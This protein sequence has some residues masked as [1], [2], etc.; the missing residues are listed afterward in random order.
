MGDSSGAAGLAVGLPQVGPVGQPAR[1][2]P[3][4]VRWLEALGVVLSPAAAALVLRLRLMAPSILPDPALHTSYI[5]EA[6][7]V[8]MRYAWLA[9]VGR[10][11]EG[12]RVG[13]LVPARLDYLAFGAVPG[14]FVTRYV[15]ALIAVGPVY[16]LLRR[17]YGPAAGVAGIVVVLSSP[18]I[19]TAWGTDY[20]DGAVVSYALGAMACLVMPGAPRWRRAWLAAAGVLMTLA[21]W[22]HLVG[23]P[24][25][26]ATLAAWLAVRL[27]RERAGLPGDLA[28]LAGVAAAVT[29]LLVLASAVLFGHANFFA[30]TWEGYRFLSQPSQTAIWHSASWR[31]APYVAYL[32]VPPAV[33]GAFAVAVLGRGRALPAP[34]LMVGVMAATQ[35]AAYALLQFAGT[36]QVLE[37]HYFSSTLWAG[38]CLAF[39]VTIAELARPLWDRPLA[40]WLP[41]AV[42]VAIPLGYEAAP[43]VPAFGWLPI[44][45]I[46]AVAVIIAAAAARASAR[47]RPRAVAAAATGLA[48]AA[49]TAAA[50]V[51]TVAPIPHHPHLPHTATGGEPAPAYASALGGSAATYIDSYRIIT[52]LPGFVGRAT[53][54]GEQI[55]LWRI[56]PK[57]YRYIQYAAGM[58]HDGFNSLKNHST[59]IRAGDLR[60]IRSRRPAQM[61]L[62]GDTAEPFAVAVRGLAPFRPSLVHAGELRAGPLVMRVWLVRLGAYYH[63]A[64]A[65]H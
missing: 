43:R 4:W 49:F 22:S 39:A 50:L 37:Q 35:V 12:G 38:V 36:V 8:F 58:Y 45:A 25:V 5:V 17:L 3:V 21:V 29:G 30:L 57:N 14:F 34:V 28:V 6:R 55:L 44:G 59:H 33:V 1:P 7:D 16:L 11:R 19:V 18:V 24:L 53:Y 15:F 60:Q 10:L 48:L 26:G 61:L 9:R 51:L 20:P 47:I 56:T 46:V 23:V 65:P 52:A 42:L 27:V 63:P 62:L 64:V 31:W 41:A 32:L 2:W 13:F 54:H 40:R